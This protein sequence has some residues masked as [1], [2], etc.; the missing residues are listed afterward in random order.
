[1][2]RAVLGYPGQPR[3]PKPPFSPASVTPRA[4]RTLLLTLV[5]TC[6]SLPAA[7]ALFQD[8][9][10]QRLF[11]QGKD[12][13]L[14]R[15]SRS[16]SGADAW[17]GQA[18]A[19]A[20]PNDAAALAR[21]GQAAERCVQL[22]PQSAPCQVAQGVVLGVEALRGGWL[23][24][25]GLLG[26]IRGAFE[27]AVALDPALFEARSHLQQLYLLVP[28]LAGG[29]RDRAEA[30]ERE[31]RERHPEQARLLRARLA[32][33]DKRWEEAE[34]ELTAIQLGDSLSFQNDV[35]QAWTTLSRQWMKA[36][37][38]ARARARFEALASQLPGLAQPVYLLGRVAAD[39][40]EHEEAIKHYTRARTLLGAEA[41]P[42]DHRIGLALEELGR[43]EA[44]REH[45][46][47]F[48]NDRQAAPNA[49]EDARK[50]LRALEN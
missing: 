7:A 14:L 25:L 35:L 36:N 4:M 11:D 19:Q 16:R 41:L 32:S 2:M 5:L 40:G 33:R 39:A 15:E 8:A 37:D 12:D 18:L 46:L 10:L 1:M 21:A 3:P 23:R 45:L 38:H 13:E 26:R 20:L 31:I 28:G 9:A 27:K 24:G 42:L 30:L 44:A 6:S 47:R 48:L 29:G 22:H 49:L 17:V 50:H 43:K 34:R